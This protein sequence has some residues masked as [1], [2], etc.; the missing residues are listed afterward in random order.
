VIDDEPVVRDAIGRVLEAAGLSVARAADGRSG[1]AH[2]AAA[3]CRLVLCDLMLPD[4]AGSEVIRKLR[5]ARP[6]LPVIAITGYATDDNAR[7]SIAAGATDFLPKPF[8]ESELLGVVRRALRHAVAA[9]REV[10]S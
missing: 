2:P 7:R 3:G 6:T 9:A 10:P 4:G 5:A 8:E 1:L